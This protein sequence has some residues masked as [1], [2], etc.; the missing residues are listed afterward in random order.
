MATSHGHVVLWN[1]CLPRHL[2]ALEHPRHTSAVEGWGWG[3]FLGV[4]LNL[5][6]LLLLLLVLRLPLMHLLHQP[7]FD[8]LQAMTPLILVP[9]PEYIKPA[10][11]PGPLCV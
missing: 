4:R 2:L 11:C 6:H 9:M 7:Q 8:P 1:A 10:C 3:W 5:G